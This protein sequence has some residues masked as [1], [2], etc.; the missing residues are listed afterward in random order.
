[1]VLEEVTLAV[2]RLENYVKSSHELLPPV[3]RRVDGDLEELN[4]V[5]VTVAKK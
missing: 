3:S 1:M 5:L 4:A 2:L